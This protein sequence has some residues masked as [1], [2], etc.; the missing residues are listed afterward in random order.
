MIG[1]T[2]AIRFTDKNGQVLMTEMD[3]PAEPTLE[4][5]AAF[6]AQSIRS[7]SH[8]PEV[9]EANRDDPMPHQAALAHFGYEI[10]DI[11]LVVEPD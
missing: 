7:V 11:K 10:V 9:I 2:W 8:H 4:Q 5:A 3:S 1:K 6:V